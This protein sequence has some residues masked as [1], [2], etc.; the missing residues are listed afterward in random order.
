[1]R[2]STSPAARWRSTGKCFEFPLLR[3]AGE[4]KPCNRRDG[5]QDEKGN[6]IKG[7]GLYL[8]AQTGALMV[9]RL[10]AGAISLSSAGTA[11][12]PGFQPMNLIVK[13]QQIDVGD[14]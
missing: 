9:C 11:R 10:R 12:K 5:V 8:T 6:L 14:A 1:M 13:G 4:E 3:D 7:M 2:E